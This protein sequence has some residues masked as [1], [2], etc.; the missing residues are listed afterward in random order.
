MRWLKRGLDKLLFSDFSPILKLGFERNLQPED[1]PDLPAH[2]DPQAQV[3][4]EDQIE[5]THGNRLL[6]TLFRALWR[7]WVPPLALFLLFGVMNLLGPILVNQFVSRL[8]QGLN[9]QMDLIWGLA[10]AVGVGA[11]GMV[12]GLAIQHYFRRNLECFQ[13]ITNLVNRRIFSH[14]L[15]LRK[16]AREKT[17]VGDIVNHMSTDTDSIAEATSAFSDLLYSILIMGGTVTLLF[18]YLGQTAWVAVIL[19]VTLAPLT[20]KVSRDFIRFDETLMKWR[21]QRVSLMAQILSAIRLVKY[22]VW[23]KSV[24]QEVSRVRKDELHSRRQIARAQLL[25]TLL[26]VSV[27]TLILFSVLAVHSLRGGEFT[28]AL[29]FTCVSLFALLEDP[30]AHISRVIS[31]VIAA[32][33][34]GDRICRFL[35]LE[36]VPESI[37]S[38]AGTGP[39]GFGM[40]RLSVHLGEEER[41]ALQDI[42]LQVRPGSSLAVIGAVGSGKSIFIHALLGEIE[43]SGGSLDFTQ[44]NG[45]P[46]AGGRIAFVP[47]EAYVLNGTLRENLSFGHPTVGDAEIERALALSCLD[48]DVAKMPGGLRTEIGEK[49]INLSGGQ[50]QR[51]SLARAIL[52]QP[53]LVVLDDPLSALDQTTETLV[54]NQL[55]FGHWQTITRVMITHRLNHLEAFDQI[56]FL[57]G[58][59]LLMVGTF[60]ELKSQ[61]SEFRSFLAEHE[62]SHGSDPGQSPPISTVA[63]NSG[64]AVRLTEDEDRHLGAV[65]RGLYWDYIL[66][67]GG[68]NKTW[69]P[70]R[71]F[72]LLFAAASATLFPLLQKSWLAYFSNLQSGGEG[73]FALLNRW[74]AVPLHAVYVYGLIGILVMVGTLSADLFWLQRGLAAGRDIHDRMLRSVLGAGIRFF[75]ATPVG[76]VLQRFSRDMEA[77]DIHLQW[78]FEHSMKCFAQVAVTLCLIIGLLPLVALILV[79]VFFVYY[80]VQKMYRASAREVKRLDSISRSPRYAHFKETLQ[81]LVVIR[82]FGR[83]DWFLTEFYRRLRHNQRMFYSHYMINRWFSSRIPL[84]GGVVAMA[85]TMGIVFAVRQGTL[86]P[87]MAGLLSVYSLS[88]WGVLNWGIRIW[89]EVEARMTSMER[90]Q[91]YMSLPQEPSV[92]VDSPIPDNWPSRGQVIFENVYARY[93]E[94]LPLVLKGLS[95][96]VPAGSK[97][98]IV[99]RTGSGKSTIFQAMYRFIELE[100]GRILVDGVDIAQV[101]LS[102][103]RRALAIIPQDPTLFMGSLRA[104]LDRYG[105][106]SDEALWAVLEQA[107]LGSFVRGLP[108]GLNTLLVEN[109]VNLSQGQR[110]LLCLARALL[111]KAKVIIVDEATASVDVQTDATVQRVLKTSCRDVTMLTIAHRLGTVRDCEQI[112]EVQDGRRITDSDLS[113][114]PKILP[115][116]S[117]SCERALV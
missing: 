67:L 17:P 28:P 36:I 33:V 93:A 68:Q 55:L 2:L 75:D 100:T 113:A 51:L 69:R 32:K 59:R 9:S 1:L 23:E 111:I 26:Y 87:G 46:T 99:G 109:G 97:V 5:W 39:I 62:L 21:D 83:T 24:A 105:E 30:F 115:L 102:R 35:A 42:S 73:G 48:S 103:L 37:E 65:R 47:Q 58:G 86:S 15:R 45:E 16:E 7:F 29:I 117:E 3:G 40:K 25:V 89:A 84:V 81:G 80:Q 108:Q 77:I 107:S 114:E 60:A 53:Q 22:F 11:V 64:E 92:L 116:F 43:R 12:G 91:Y 98:G 27:G 88:F 94:H 74:A 13:I 78:S 31:M 61:C 14:A 63:L 20:R 95:F 70:L 49:G 34:G 6:F 76:R 19:L 57:A 56:A 44:V 72:L 85:T 104:N 96:E 82:A 112:F 52:H 8:S 90:V 10:Y 41:A 50:R 18:Y 79:P 101:P 106:H 4:V 110:Q 54:V 66:A 38:T 71:L